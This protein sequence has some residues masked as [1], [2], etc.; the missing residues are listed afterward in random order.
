MK[1]TASAGLSTRKRPW[2]F[3]RKRKVERGK[4]E[5]GKRIPLLIIS[6]AESNG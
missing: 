5:D 2:G 1:R 3:L 4:I 6:K